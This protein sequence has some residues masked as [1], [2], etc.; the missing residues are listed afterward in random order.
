MWL[1]LLLWCRRLARM[2][3]LSCYWINQSGVKA[4]ALQSLQRRFVISRWVYFVDCAALGCQM[5]ELLHAFTLILAEVEA[6]MLAYILRG[7]VPWPIV[8][9]C[10]LLGYFLELVAPSQPGSPQDAI[11]IGGVGWV[12]R[13]PHRK[14]K[15]QPGHLEPHLR[16]VDLP[17]KPKRRFADDLVAQQQNS[18]GVIGCFLA[19]WIVWQDIQPRAE[20]IRPQDLCQDY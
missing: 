16:Q 1:L 11:Q 14:D 19:S 15:W 20:K 8:Q 2:L 7:Q 12:G 10:V 9:A 17:V 18:L 3:F 6:K 4:A 5:E 13:R